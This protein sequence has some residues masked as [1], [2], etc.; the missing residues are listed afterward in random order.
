M[1]SK[2]SVVCTV[3]LKWT[4][5]S[6]SLGTTKWLPKNA[7]S[8]N[9]KSPFSN[10]QVLKILLVT[11][12]YKC[13]DNSRLPCVKCLEGPQNNWSGVTWW[14]NAPFF[15]LLVSYYCFSFLYSFRWK[16]TLNNFSNH[17]Q[18]CPTI[19]VLSSAKCNL[20]LRLDIFFLYSF[21]C[22]C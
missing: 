10:E 5:S 22:F 15:C 8:N 2:Q 20:Q 9:S 3:V 18:N 7:K 13:N 16:R 12:W 19:K 1:L 11:S 14:A 4:N 21:H 17:E 6:R